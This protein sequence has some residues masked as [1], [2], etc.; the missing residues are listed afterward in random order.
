MMR[1]FDSLEKRHYSLHFRS[2]KWLLLEE[3]PLSLQD[4]FLRREIDMYANASSF[5][6]FP[7]TPRPFDMA[8]IA[9]DSSRADSCADGLAL[10]HS[11]LSLDL[12]K[13]ALLIQCKADLAKALR[14]EDVCTG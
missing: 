5:V 4:E 7:L 3:L 13:P 6:S 8:L 1:C 14:P 10:M 9:C 12:E 2:D 11:F